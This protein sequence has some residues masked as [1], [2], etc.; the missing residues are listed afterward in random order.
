MRHVYQM[1]GC[2]DSV[3]GTG[4]LYNLGAQVI[5]VA[6]ERI[7]ENRRLGVWIRPGPGSGF[8]YL[9]FRYLE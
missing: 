3:R 8:L 6:T 4:L 5:F 2:F 9:Y 1:A 7:G